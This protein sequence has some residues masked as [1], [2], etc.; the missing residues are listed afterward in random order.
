MV[1]FWVYLFLLVLFTEFFMAMKEVIVVV[2]MEGVDLVLN[3]PATLPFKNVEKVL[4]VM[5]EVDIGPRPSNLPPLIQVGLVDHLVS[6]LMVIRE[7][8][9][10]LTPENFLPITMVDYTFSTQGSF[11]RIFLGV[12]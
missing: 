1:N 4:I 5:G 11:K 12:Y 3:I 7:V 2:M 8:C 10:Y 6:L 9:I